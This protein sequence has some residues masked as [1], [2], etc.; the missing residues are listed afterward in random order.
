MKRVSPKSVMLAGPKFKIS[1]I[2]YKVSELTF[3]GGKNAFTS[4]A[5]ACG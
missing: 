1:K 4:S 2:S 5:F 3:Q